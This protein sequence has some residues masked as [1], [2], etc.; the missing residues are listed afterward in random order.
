MLKKLLR[1]TYIIV[2]IALST[3][4][5]CATEV[6]APAE[7]IMQQEISEVIETPEPSEEI[8]IQ[9]SPTAIPTVLPSVK[10]SVTPSKSPIPSV[11]PTPSASLTPMP[12]P[13]ERYKYTGINISIDASKCPELTEPIIV[14]LYHKKTKE[15]IKFEFN[16]QMYKN[17]E[18]LQQGIK[19]GTYSIKITG[20]NSSKYM[21]YTQEENRFG[22]TLEATKD[23]YRLQLIVKKV[24]ENISDEPAYSQGIKKQITDKYDE[25]A[26]KLWRSFRLSLIA[27]KDDPNFESIIN[28]VNSRESQIASDY[29]I[30][31]GNDKSEYINM[32]IVTKFALYSA[33]VSPASYSLSGDFDTYFGSLDKFESYTVG[34]TYNMLK[35]LE[36][37]NVEQTY[38]ALMQWQYQYFS[39]HGL[40]YDFLENSAYNE[41]EF[42]IK[43][44]IQPEVKEVKKKGIW[45]DTIDAIKKHIVSICICLVLLLILLGIKL[46]KKHKTIDDEE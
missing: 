17:N 15:E 41:D 33:Y 38:R 37:T 7:E 4:S 8:D 30:I 31:T 40:M 21:L 32:N 25:E 13:T 5:I 1:A 28:T 35:Q 42:I 45:D 11:A 43:Q 46:Y 26:D 34:T 16:K 10:S 27:A 39:E 29:E 36:D 22:D 23:R 19:Q 2:S 14:K 20:L 18:V 6:T 12:S 24:D 44:E 9:P 3:V